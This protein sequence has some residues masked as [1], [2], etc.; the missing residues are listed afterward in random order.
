MDSLIQSN[1]K[2]AVG[3]CDNPSVIIFSEKLLEGEQ[4]IINGDGKQTRDYVFVDDV[5]RAN[6]L[7]LKKN[8][9][10]EFNIGT[11][12]ETNVNQ[13]FNLLVELT[14]I[15][16]KEIHG[17]AKA[18]EQRRSC[19]SCEKAKKI[20]GWEPKVTLHQGLAKTVEFFRKIS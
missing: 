8:V 11:G 19:L 2:D 3:R 15:K 18:G 17:L 13:I 16:K 14:G 10:G 9:K 4:P 6:I 7:V 5:V 20:I 12:R 1:K